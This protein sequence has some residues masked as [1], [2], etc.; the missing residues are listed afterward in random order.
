MVEKWRYLPAWCLKRIKVAPGEDMEELEAIG[1][2]VLMKAVAKFDPSY[3]V[4]FNTFGVRCI[5]QAMNRQAHGPRSDKKLDASLD[6]ILSEDPESRAG[7]VMEDRHPGDDVEAAG[8]TALLSCL[9]VRDRQIVILKIMQDWTLEEIGKVYG[10]T[11]E[12]VRQIID[13]AMKR[14]REAHKECA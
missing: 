11:R 14:V 10:I 7:L 12:G 1:T 2:V 9:S 5:C 13:R 3:G 6:V 8:A 4:K